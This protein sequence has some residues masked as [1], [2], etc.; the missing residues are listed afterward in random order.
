M[1]CHWT[2]P[3][4]RLHPRTR[5]RQIRTVRRALACKSS[6]IPRFC[7][8]ART[9]SG[10]ARTTRRRIGAL[11]SAAL[12][13]LLGACAPLVAAARAVVARTASP[14][15]PGANMLPGASNAAAIGAATVCLINQ[16]RG[17][18]HR[19]RLGANRSLQRVATA[20]VRQMVHWNYF[21]DVRPSGQTPAALIA[22]SGYAAHGGSVAS[23][24]NIGWGTGA[25][26]TPAAMVAGW[27]ASPSHRALILA[28]VFHDIGVGVSPRLPGNLG[29][30]PLGA[31]Y[32]VEFG[33]RAG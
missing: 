26:T 9:L 10:R 23:G 27:M 17:L 3:Q 19:H 21:A 6:L 5:Q 11:V 2:T 14:P 24:Q 22:S 31:V 32:A 16:L 20:Q 33:A 18:H 12:A 4:Q 15:C 1:S 29:R 13:L 8:H 28:R 7:K 25:E 30:G